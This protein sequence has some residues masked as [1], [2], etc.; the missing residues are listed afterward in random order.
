MI[1]TKT[2]IKLKKNNTKQNQQKGEKI[3]RKRKENK[4]NRRQIKPQLLEIGVNRNQLHDNKMRQESIG[5][6]K[7]S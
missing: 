7:R 4:I 5:L 1:Q 3:N 6:N 2:K